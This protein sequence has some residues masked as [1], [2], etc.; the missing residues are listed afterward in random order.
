MNRMLKQ[1]LQMTEIIRLESE[2]IDTLYLLLLQHVITEDEEFQKVTE[3]IEEASEMLPFEMIE[4][5]R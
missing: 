3:M 4:Q 2:I 1:I 5:L